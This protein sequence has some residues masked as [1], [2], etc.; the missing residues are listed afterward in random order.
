M[1]NVHDQHEH[2]YALRDITRRTLTAFRDLQQTQKP[3]PKESDTDTSGIGSS[4]WVPHFFLALVLRSSRPSGRPRAAR[5]PILPFMRPHS[6]SGSPLGSVASRVRVSA[7]STRLEFCGA[8]TYEHQSP[9][10]T[11]RVQNQA[12]VSAMNQ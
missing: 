11:A 3:P 5:S 10:S 12:S 6:E 9:R 8:P 1:T 7:V 2:A 4:W